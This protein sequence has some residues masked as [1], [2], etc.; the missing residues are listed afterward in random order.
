MKRV[1]KTFPTLV[2]KVNAVNQGPPLGWQ[3]STALELETLLSST[4]KET[5][6]APSG[7]YDPDPKTLGS[8]TAVMITARHATSASCMHGPIG[9]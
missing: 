1:S 7:T 9:L 6:P 2:S 8:K 5:P 3:E 4:K